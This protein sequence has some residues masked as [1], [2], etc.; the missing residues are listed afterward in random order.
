MKM[1]L[2]FLVR[3]SFF[4]SLLYGGLVSASA[5]QFADVVQKDSD[6][7]GQKLEQKK[8]DDA[9]DGK[10]VEKGVE[11]NSAL[12]LPQ[13]PPPPI[14]KDIPVPQYKGPLANASAQTAL[15]LLLPLMIAQDVGNMVRLMKGVSASQARDIVVKVLAQKDSVL[16]ADDK[17]RLIIGIVATYYATD[18]SSQQLL[19]D[20]ILRY[21][22]VPSNPL[23]F[24]AV[25]YKYSQAI[26]PLLSWAE[27]VVTLKNKKAPEWLKD[28]AF[29]SIQ[30]AVLSNDFKSFSALLKNGIV[31][32]PEQAGQLFLDAAGVK[33]ARVDFIVPLVRLKANLNSI[34]TQL[35]YYTPLMKATS[36]GNLAFVKALF[37]AGAKINKI[38]DPALQ[39]AI[40]KKQLAIE[41][42][43]REQGA[44]E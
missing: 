40:K 16:T 37:K 33:N 38:D 20:L 28:D 19:F 12:V 7:L 14:F 42:F 26:K 30:T 29:K 10:V 41:V 18:K 24:I 34:D 35:D 25:R 11:K 2:F 36:V 23:A 4:L 13:P 43:L 39:V 22:L 15:E 8:S 6:I 31:V 32:T 21:A 9:L 44:Q 3:V 5:E 17:V 1:R 27:A